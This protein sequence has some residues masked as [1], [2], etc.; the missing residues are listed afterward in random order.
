MPDTTARDLVTAAHLEL[1]AVAA[2]ETLTASD[3]TVGLDA[4]NRLIDQYRAEN[5]T[6]YTT[7]RTTWTLVSSTQTYTVGSGGTGPA[8]ARPVSLLGCGYIE[9]ADTPDSEH[10]L[11]P[12]DDAGWAAV[13]QKALTAVL[14]T[15]YHYN[16]TY[17]L[18]TLTLWP[19]PTSST[20]QGVVYAKTALTEFASLS[21]AVSL[22]PGYRRMLVKNLALELAPGLGKTVS[23]ELALA[24]ADSLSV[25]K[26]QN[27]QIP[28]MSFPSDSLGVGGGTAYDI[29][30][31]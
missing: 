19:A 15:N 4:L 7:T 5:L 13:T 26:R 10:A 30:I 14:P 17:P 27:V 1:L 12:F 29:A 9:T 2:G 21:T 20:L 6:I 23:R 16:P 28:P 25:V 11:T 3:A 31:G 22:P 24:A 8:I 18:A